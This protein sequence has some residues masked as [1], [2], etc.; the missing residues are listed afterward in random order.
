M[1]TSNSKLNCKI[2]TDLGH[3]GH[4]T[5]KQENRVYC[6]TP[7]AIART[8]ILDISLAVEIDRERTKADRDRYQ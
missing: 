2:S 4:E 5:R 7:A 3:V 1:L 8:G 6:A